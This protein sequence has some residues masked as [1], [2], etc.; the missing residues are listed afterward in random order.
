VNFVEARFPFFF[1]AVFL[2]HWGLRSARGR[3]VLLLAA[4]YV[5]Y[6]AWDARF[7]AL[8]VAS[9]L[10]DYAAGLGIERARSRA[11]R[12]A[13][14]TL[15]L[16][17]NLGLLATFK[18]L[19]FFIASAL[20]LST[21]LGLRELGLAP[22]ERSLGLILPVGIS[23]Y[24]F[25]TLSY[26]IDVYRGKLR[27][28]RDLLDL[29]LFVG[30]FPQLVAGPIVRAADF[31]PQLRAPRVFARV[32]V[33][34]ALWLFLFGF[35]KKAC[36][37][38][39]AARVVDVVF[40]DPAL[41]D[42]GSRALAA[43]LYAVQI[44]GDFSGYSDMAIA[45][46]ALLGYALPEN[47]R[48]PYLAASITDFWRRWHITL[49]TWFRDYLYIPLGGNRG[50]RARTM[51]NLVLVF[52][53]CGLWHGARWT[54]V[55]WGAWHGAFLVLERVGGGRWLERVPSPARRGYA[56][57]VVL[58]GWVLFRAESVAAAWSLLTARPGASHVSAALAWW[59][60]AAALLAAQAL[61]ARGV[62]Q[63]RLARLRDERFALAYGVAVA[64]TLS[65]VSLDH[66]PFIYFAF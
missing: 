21:A 23:F 1:L 35:F 33:R 39:N 66:K 45:C 16:V 26:S 25:Q 34:P 29:A 50:G 58:L 36:L 7:L 10:V 2:L 48:A 5:F 14:M 31:L 44:Y 19:D 63:P 15:S 60:L 55:L 13:W 43:V 4:S 59:T 64:L 9:T 57:L 37:A 53:L 30:F 47:F 42:L 8:I 41:W 38:D 24:T 11:P 12:R 17:A 52:L 61:G 22:G 40:D 6:G 3:K 20:E 51:R 65:L 27:A 56:L 46:A 54:F 32:A 28:T 18:Y 49:S 62:V